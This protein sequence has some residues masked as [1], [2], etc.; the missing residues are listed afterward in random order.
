MATAGGLINNPMMSAAAMHYG[1][2][3]AQRSQAYVDQGVRR[4]KLVFAMIHMP[5][6]VGQPNAGH[7]QSKDLLCCGHKLCPEEDFHSPVPILTPELDVT[8]QS[9]RTCGSKRGH[10]CSRPLHPRY[11]LTVQQHV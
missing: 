3:I 5:S 6:L 1:S 4:E 2:E 10:Q 8:V 7:H 9:D 11:E